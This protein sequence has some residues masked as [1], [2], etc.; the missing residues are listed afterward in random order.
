MRKLA[1]RLRSFRRDRNGFAAFEFA[2]IAPILILLYFGTVDL[3]NWYMAHRK[4]VVAGSTI[5]DLTTQSQGQVT[6]SGIN[7]LWTGIGQII[8]PL[9]LTDVAMTLRAYRRTG[10]A[11]SQIWTHSQNGTCGGALTGEQLAAMGTNEMTDGNDILL[12]SVCTT[13]APIAL[14]AFGWTSIPLEYQIS[15]RPRLGKTLD[16]SGGC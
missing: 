2:I 9:Q 4:L 5:A 3:A 14:Q 6:A 7:A 12:A 1:D 13:V 8:A 15:M 16:C 11:V 10:G